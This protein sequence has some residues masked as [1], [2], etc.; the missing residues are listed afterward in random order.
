MIDQ[1]HDAPPPPDW[2]FSVLGPLRG[3]YRD[4]EVDLGSR[5]Q[6]A[7]LAALLLRDGAQVGIEELVDGL[8]RDA[9]RAAVGTV[10]THLS[11]L[12]R[13]LNP[14]GDA[15]RVIRSAAGGYHLPSA[16]FSLDL[17]GFRHLLDASST[18]PT[19]DA[20]RGLRAA[21]HLWCG[22]AL[23]G[24]PG[25]YLEGQRRRLMLM[26][27][28]ALE[29]RI[30]IDIEQGRCVEALADLVVVAAE[31]PYDE[32][33]CA[34]H[35]RTLWKLGR[36]AEALAEYHRIRGL[37]AAEVGVDPGLALQDL[38]LRILSSADNAGRLRRKLPRSPG[39]SMMLLGAGGG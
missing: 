24:L 30:A 23:L 3:W 18:A 22:T 20:A 6:Q 21:L 28:A 36:R 32:A 15:D 7:V 31:Q 27:S 14:S 19:D 26:R 39:R 5:Q 11:R 37:L 12:N 33:L 17:T 8:W 34:L 4:T 25:P 29:R 13:L 1:R 16:T 9:P 35:M 2:T 10:R 38:Y